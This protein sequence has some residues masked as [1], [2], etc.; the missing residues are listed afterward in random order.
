M[1]NHKT[2]KHKVKLKSI[3]EWLPNG[4]CR[5]APINEALKYICSGGDLPISVIKQR[6]KSLTIS[7]ECSNMVYEKIKL[8][9]V[10]DVGHKFIWED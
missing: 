7:I 10:R 6:T 9:F 5:Y 3:V 2:N 8:C 1:E 4:N